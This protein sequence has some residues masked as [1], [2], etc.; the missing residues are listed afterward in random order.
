MVIRNDM[1]IGLVVGGLALLLLL[2]IGYLA[3]TPSAPTT[4]S[5]TGADG[6][7][8]VIPDS[9]TPT[10][11]DRDAR[12]VAGGPATPPEAAPTT[13]TPGDSAN[14]IAQVTPV[15]Q[16]GGTASP[17]SSSSDNPWATIYAG[18]PAQGDG[19]APVVERTPDPYADA[20]APTFE[21]GNLPPL[22]MATTPSSTSTSTP[23]RPAFT[24]NVFGNGPPATP[25]STGSPAPSPAT[26]GTTSGG[27]GSTHTV[28]EGE[29]F[30]TI[31]RAAYG[32]GDLYPAI[33]AANPSVD[34]SRL[35]VGAVLNLPPEPQVKT[36]AATTPAT[37]AASAIPAIAGPVAVGPNQYR[38]E[39]GDTLSAIAAKRLGS[40]ARW[41][42]I[43]DRNRDQIGD[44][45]AALKVNAVLEIPQPAGR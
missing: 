42:A 6:D 33:A 32:D 22:A 36:A 35:K 2:L 25:A 17:T 20:P 11:P 45:P 1:K 9:A 41:E 18:G 19:P 5:A 10:A 31:A 23:S 13:P 14:R 15:E 4:A 24:P 26:S 7:E 28:A 38:V 29:S 16:A 12:A 40:S 43:Y 34:P 44:D 27:S 30:Y 37:T 21:R 3:I 39:P 8:I